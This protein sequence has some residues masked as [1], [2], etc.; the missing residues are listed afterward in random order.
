MID[1]KQAFQFAK[2][3]ATGMLGERF[4]RLE[5]LERDTYKGREVWRVTLGYPQDKTLVDAVSPMRALGFGPLEYK[6]FII[7]AANGDLVAMKLREPS[8]Q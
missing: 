1:G 4:F 8:L 7:D 2:Q 3:Q 6:L 5:E